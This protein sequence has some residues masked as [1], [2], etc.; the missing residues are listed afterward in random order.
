MVDLG[1]VNRRSW[2]AH[3]R[4]QLPGLG[5]P[6]RDR[7]HDEKGAEHRLPS[8]SSAPRGICGCRPELAVS[9]SQS[10]RQPEA[11]HGGGRRRR[12]QYRLRAATRTKKTRTARAAACMICVLPAR[13]KA[14]ATRTGSAPRCRSQPKLNAARGSRAPRSALAA[15]EEDLENDASLTQCPGQGGVRRRPR[16]W[17]YP[18]TLRYPG[19][20]LPV[21]PSTEDAHARRQR[22]VA[23]P[24]PTTAWMPT[25]AD[26]R[27]VRRCAAASVT[28]AARG[29]AASMPR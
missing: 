1:F 26:V 8:P 20:T 7:E 16:T 27:R 18:T 11:R 19:S 6:A 17:T 4:L 25:P 24:Q 2:R 12:R 29:R 9:R 23:S 28:T 10:H 15:D 21:L 5:S 13:A 22:E 14:A 3:F